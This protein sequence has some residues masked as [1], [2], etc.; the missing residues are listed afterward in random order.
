MGVAAGAGLGESTLLWDDFVWVL[1]L[2]LRSSG[3]HLCGVPAVAAVGETFV[4]QP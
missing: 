2:G 1:L 4:N 3:P